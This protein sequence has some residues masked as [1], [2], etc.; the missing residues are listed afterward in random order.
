MWQLGERKAIATHPSLAS[1]SALHAGSSIGSTRPTGLETPSYRHVVA[2]PALLAHVTFALGAMR[3][4]LSGLLQPV[5]DALAD[6]KGSFHVGVQ[7]GTGATVLLST[8]G[9][10]HV[11]HPSNAFSEVHV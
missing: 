6:Q 3:P 1:Q 10:L 8:Q 5:L 4:A 9:V 7:S 2:V 11:V